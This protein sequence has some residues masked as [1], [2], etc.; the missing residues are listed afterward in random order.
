MTTPAELTSAITTVTAEWLASGR[1][2]T[3]REIG[4]GHCYDFAEEVLRRLGRRDLYGHGYDPTK[5]SLQEARTEDFWFDDFCADMAL[6]RAS[7]ETIPDDIPESEV[8]DIIGS[9]SHAWFVL[10]G[11]HYDATAPEG[12]DG[13]LQMPF[14][15]DQF[16]GWREENAA[17]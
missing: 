13:F 2:A 10:E 8:E 6:V 16:A 3:V 11:R 5:P 7:G 4:D 12:R 14:F 9:A 17:A 15:A 1:V